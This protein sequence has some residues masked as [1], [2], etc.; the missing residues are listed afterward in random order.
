MGSMTYN[1]ISFYKYT[2]LENPEDFRDLLRMHCEELNILGRILIGTEGLNGAVCGKVEDIV[3]FKDVLLASPLFADLT[4]REQDYEK[5][6]Y[7]KLVVR[8]RKEICAFG[9]DVNVAGKGTY[10]EPAELQRWYEENED[11][12]IV[13]ARNDYEFDVGRFKDAVKLPIQNFREFGD[14]APKFLEG[15]K[16]KKM[17]LYCTGGIRCEK[18]SAYMK[19]QGFSNVYHVKGG[20]INYVNQFPESNWEGGLFVFDDRLVSEHG[21]A[22]TECVRCSTK[23]QKMI[24]CHNLDCDKLVVVCENCGKHC[25]AECQNAAKQRKKKVVETVIGTVEHYYGKNKVAL[26][27]L[28]GSLKR[29]MTI[30]IKGKTTHISHTISELRDADGNEI[31]E[32]ENQLVTF[33]VSEKVRVN[34]KVLIS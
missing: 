7:H 26:V 27:T 2:T 21:S 4:F 9:K 11:F 29:D 20:I 28:H 24:N 16:D 30:T 5:N 1:V 12:V 6:T 10:L 17:V 23:T 34:D 25:S 22:I 19:E 31:E 14:V 3:K 32:A 18:A 15:D 8:V 13:D 33:P